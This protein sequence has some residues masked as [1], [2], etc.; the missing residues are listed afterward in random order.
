MD[1]GEVAGKVEVEA[2]VGVS[3][4]GGIGNE[5][6]PWI[7]QVNHNRIWTAPMI[8]LLNRMNCIP[9]N[10]PLSSAH[11]NTTDLRS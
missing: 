11:G 1:G 9:M 4:V 10:L 6:T 7:G 8:L 5:G 3:E 2:E